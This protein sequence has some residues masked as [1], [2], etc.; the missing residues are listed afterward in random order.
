MSNAQLTLCKLRV[1]ELINE[2]INKEE[3]GNKKGLLEN[4]LVHV[5]RER[6]VQHV[7]PTEV[8]EA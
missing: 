5:L 8:W 7:Y 6:D 2:V 3:S 4:E 1:L